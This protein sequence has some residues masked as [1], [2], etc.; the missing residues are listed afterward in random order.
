M[1]DTR[2]PHRARTD[3]SSDGGPARG[4]PL[5]RRGFLRIAGL[6]AGTLAVA[7]AAGLTWKAVDGGVFAS[8]T[9]AAYSAWDLVTSTARGPLAMVQA[10]VLAA[11]A[12][13]AQPWLFTISQD[14]IDVFADTSRNLGAMDPL[15]R[16]MHISL[17]CAVENLVVAGPSN[18]FAPRVALLP[19]PS[20]STHVASLE[21]VPTSGSAS[22]HYPAIWTRHTDRAAYD[23]ARPIADEDLDALGAVVDD[24]STRLVWFTAAGQHQEFG[25]LTIRATEAIIADEG[26]SAA[27]YAWY[28]TSW[29][30]IQTRKDGITIDPSGK[31]PVIRALAKLLPVTQEQN[32]AGWLSGTHDVQ[33]PT[34]AAFGAL[35]V[36]GRHDAAQHLAVGRSW[37]RL[38]LQATTAGLSMQP[39]CQVPERIDREE[40]TGQEPVFTTA[41]QDLLP[42][43]THPIMTFRIGHPTADALRSPR[44]PASDV[45]TS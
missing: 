29:Q 13:N 5:D 36:P 9:G 14:R 43:G 27:D 25:D 1:T 20:D 18:G 6:G 31:P 37:Q 33:V 7:G 4:A 30:Q 24:P 38:H 8:G 19:N 15:L 2:A 32:N 40:S 34:A 22:P 16:E 28:R 3:G 11:N 23:T 26:Q 17:G 21:L 35:V 42:A 44:R 12:H 39:L 41:M 10:A 45:V